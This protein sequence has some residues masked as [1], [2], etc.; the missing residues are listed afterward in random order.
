[1]GLILCRNK[2]CVLIVAYLR[3]SEAYYLDS[4]RQHKK[5]NY[6]HIKSV[7]NDALTGYAFQGGPME[8]QKQKDGNLEIGRA[9]V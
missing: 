6:E 1:M 7:M 5:K 3:V 4:G 8:V 9:H 2:Y